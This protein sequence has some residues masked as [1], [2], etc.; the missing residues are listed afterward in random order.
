MKID[1]RKFIQSSIAATMASTVTPALA[2]ILAQQKLG[3][4][5]HS[6]ASRWRPKE[7]SAKY[8]GFK[9][10]AALLEH[11]ASIGA[12]GIQVIVDG[13]STD[14]SKQVRTQREKLGM[15]IEGSIGLPKTTDDVAQFEKNILSAKEAGA[16]V[17][18]TVCL[19]GRRYESFKT[20][21]EF[22]VFTTASVK[23]IQLAEPVVRKHQVK[24][25]VENHKDW[26]APELAAIMKVINSEWV[27]VTLDFGNSISLLE[28]SMEVVNHLLPYLF[29]THVKDM[30]LDEYKDGFMMSEVPLGTGIIDLKKVFDLCRAKN[31][32]V[33]FNLEMITR[34]P[35]EI[36][37]FRSDYWATFS[38]VRGSALAST[39]R[40]VREKKSQQPLPRVSQLS[41]DERL[42]VEEKNINLSISYSDQKLQPQ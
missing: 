24:L 29:S 31:P 28:D 37:C 16:T 30:G 23:S 18:R 38:E 9:D 8:P 32:N 7:E 19:N 10:A 14:F 22:K 17:V 42:E 36:P 2:N 13:W 26:R 39:I 1:R 41:L 5:V 21:E 15:Y 4:V 12:G 6:Y 40:L 27:G 34:D 3:I 20:A 25:A 11:C 35:L 33:T